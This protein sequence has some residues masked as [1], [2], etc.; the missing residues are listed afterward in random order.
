MFRKHMIWFDWVAMLPQRFT[1]LRGMELIDVPWPRQFAAVEKE[2]S[3]KRPT[4]CNFDPQIPWFSS[5]FMNFFGDHGIFNHFSIIF[6]RITPV[7][8]QSFFLAF[9]G[10]KSPSLKVPLLIMACFVVRTGTGFPSLWLQQKPP[11]TWEVLDLDQLLHTV[12]SSSDTVESRWVSFGTK[13][14]QATKSNQIVSDGEATGFPKNIWAQLFVNWGTNLCKYFLC[15][16]SC[17]PCSKDTEHQA[18][19]GLS[20]AYLRG[21]THGLPVEI[22]EFTATN[23]DASFK[24]YGTVF[25]NFYP[26]VLQHSYGN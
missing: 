23:A 3:R 13:K 4:D 2:R 1:V 15:P 11:V 8:L 21:A 20:Y 24:V 10:E 18:L 7:H 22:A 26:V 19:Y 17:F 14:K 25:N 12:D 9:L 6:R 5:M 16:K